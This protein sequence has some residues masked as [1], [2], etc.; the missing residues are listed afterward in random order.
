MNSFAPGPEPQFAFGVWAFMGGMD[1][2][3]GKDYNLFP[4]E[5]EVFELTAPHT[6]SDTFEKIHQ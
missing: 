1:D 3:F 2:R 6:T 5:E 4:L